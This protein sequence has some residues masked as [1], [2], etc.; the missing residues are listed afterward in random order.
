[1]RIFYVLDC[2]PSFPT[3]FL[4]LD[5]LVTKVDGQCAISAYFDSHYMEASNLKKVFVEDALSRC[6][7]LYLIQAKRLMRRFLRVTTN[8]RMKFTMESVKYDS[9]EIVEPTADI[10]FIIT[11]AWYCGPVRLIA[12]DRNGDYLGTVVVNVAAGSNVFEDWSLFLDEFIQYALEIKPQML[13]VS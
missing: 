3:R 7:Y 8:K 13:S 11:S 2:V 5:D 1:M 10:D 9:L 12:N 6:E 4:S